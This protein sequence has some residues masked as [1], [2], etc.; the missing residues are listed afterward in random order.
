MFSFVPERASGQALGFSLFFL[1]LLGSFAPAASRA[2]QHDPLLPKLFDKLRQTEGST[3]AVVQRLIWLAWYKVPAGGDQAAFDA[4][5]AD[6]ADGNFDGAKS[7]LTQFITAYPGFSEAHNQLAIIHFALGQDTQALAA[8]YQTLALE[9]RHFGAWAGMAQIQFR[10][11]DYLAA[12]EA[13][14]AA[15]AINPQLHRLRD[16]HAAA[17]RELA[18][19]SV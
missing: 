5:L 12:L 2:D 16:L 19:E 1:L 8:I 14:E 18:Q 10:A 13:A 9:P 3:H 17:R 7:A 6:V 4:A 11:G 15:L